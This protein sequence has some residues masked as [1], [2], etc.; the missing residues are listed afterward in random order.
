MFTLYY[1]QK[2]LDGRLLQ[3]NPAWPITYYGIFPT[4]LAVFFE[5]QMF[6]PSARLG[7]T[8]SI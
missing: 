3:N 2:G 5:K 1:S 8:K 7:D 4:K 6:N